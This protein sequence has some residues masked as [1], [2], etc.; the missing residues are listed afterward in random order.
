MTKRM[1]IVAGTLALALGV[2]FLGGWSLHQSRGASSHSAAATGTISGNLLAVRGPVDVPPR[3]LRGKVVVKDSSTG[4]S[5][6]IDIVVVGADARYSVA[7]RPGTYTVTGSSPMYDGG[8]TPCPAG[9]PVVVPGGGN[10]FVNVLCQE[11]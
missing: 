2:G 11:R 10:V 5:G 1:A 4:M 3:P 8:H 7:V 6:D 9:V